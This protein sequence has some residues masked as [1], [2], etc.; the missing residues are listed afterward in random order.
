M[1][2]KTVV[3]SESQTEGCEAASVEDDMMS[4]S[5]ALN[6]TGLCGLFAFL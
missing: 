1:D 6:L 2:N 4:G 3:A 5:L